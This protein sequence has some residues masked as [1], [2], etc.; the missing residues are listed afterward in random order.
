[1]AG[2]TRRLLPRRLRGGV[3]AD[4]AALN[5][6]RNPRRTAATAGAL[7]VGVTLISM[8][9]VGAASVSANEARALDRIA[10]VDITV[11]G[12]TMPAA[13][14][15]RA[16]QVDGV[17]DVV[18]VRGEVVHSPFGKVQIGSLSAAAAAATVRD[19]GLRAELA[20]PS[21]LV[22]PL[23]AQSQVP[24]SGT[25]ELRSA[26]VRVRLHPV[27]SGLTSGPM[28][29]APSVLNRLGGPRQVE[30]LYVRI[31]TGADPQA[32][33]SGLEDAVGS[34]AGSADLRVDGG[35]VERSTYDRAISVMLL[36]ATAL[37]GMSVLIALVGVGNTLSLS[38]LERSREHGLL[39]ALGL[40]TRQLRLLL[41]NEALLMAGAAVLLGTALGVGYGWIGT[42]TLLHGTTSHA[43]VLALPV[44]RLVLIAAV[45]MVAG[46]LASVLP[47]RRAVRVAPVE[48]L[49]DA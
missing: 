7:L 34:V 17:Q 3:P 8:M 40:T 32:V 36:V 18:S 42:A 26:G 25:V 48:A 39:R 14:V 2:W 16:R 11:A 38:V 37:L 28:L 33:A 35:Y 30:A 15:A 45:A 41:A 31:S 43:P 13:V 5:A 6:V 1:M 46:L 44:T 20:D 9:S 47:A 12:G 27:F 23:S 10:P 21:A 29:V 24:E 22:L 19:E 49:R 4:L